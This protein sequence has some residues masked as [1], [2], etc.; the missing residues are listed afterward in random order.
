MQEPG[1]DSQWLQGTCLSQ[2]DFPVT[3][4]RLDPDLGLSDP[5]AWTSFL[6]PGDL[7]EDECV[8]QFPQDQKPASGCSLTKISNT[9]C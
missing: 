9:E 4:I 1:L 7:P 3:E 8:P 6:G 5:K 2:A